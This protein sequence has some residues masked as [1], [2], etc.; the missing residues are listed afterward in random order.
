M[1]DSI[2]TILVY[3]PASVKQAARERAKDQSRSLSAECARILTRE[4][5]PAESTA[6]K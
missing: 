3:V 2:E 6:T 1:N 5:K 4:F